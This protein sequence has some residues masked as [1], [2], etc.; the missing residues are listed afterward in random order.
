MNTRLTDRESVAERLL[1]SSLTHSYEPS[2]DIDWDAELVDGLYGM[3]P[4]RCSLYGTELWEGLT[5][6]QRVTLSIHE[7]CSIARVG[8]WFEMILMQMLLRYAYDRDPRTGHVQYALTE[9]SDECRHSIMFAKMAERFGVPDYAPRWLTHQL[10]RLYKATGAGPS[11]FAAVLVAEETL[12]QLQ[13]EAMRDERVQP[14][15]RMVSRIH[16]TEEARH[17]RYARE[18][19]A[20]L[21]PRLTPL[22]R[23]LARALTPLVAF[24]VVRNYVHPDVYASVGLDPTAARKVAL[25]NPHHRDTIAWSARKLTPFLREVGIIGGRSPGSGVA[26]VCSECAGG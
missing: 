1:R 14:L 24:V 17:V 15:S 5:E 10:G 11:M 25:A 18:E 20:R 2:I 19:L 23:E 7:F 13:R 6:E 16:V 22:Q 12:D 26:P 9:I 8:L 21:M 4:E 3:A